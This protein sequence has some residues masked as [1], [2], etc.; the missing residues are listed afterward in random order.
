[1]ALNDFRSYPSAVLEFEPGVTVFVGENGQG[2]T[3]IVEAIAYLATFS[4]HR[5]AADAALV[6][7]GGP[8]AVIRAKAHDGERE[9]LLEIEIIAGRANRARLNRGTVKP[10]ELLG[11]LRAVVFAPEDLQLVSGDPG[12]RRRFLDDAAIQQRPRMAG[13]RAEYDKVLR[14]RTALLKSSAAARRRGHEIDKI[15]FA[16]WDER[17]AELGAQIIAHRAELVRDLRPHVRAMYEKIAPGRGVPHLAY[18]AN[19]DEASKALLAPHDVDRGE[20]DLEREE[21]LRDIA[22]VRDRLQVSIA[23]LKDREIDRGVNLVGP[24]RDDLVLGLGTLPAKGFASH[25]ET[26]S[27]ALSLRLAEWALL[28]ESD[29]SDPILILDD[30]F[31]ELDVRRRSALAEFVVGTEQVFI[32][33]A[34]GDAIPPQLDGSRFRVHEGVVSRDR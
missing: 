24:H 21:S 23:A 14:Q 9:T 4:S 10:R 30:V 15:S 18:E 20:G 25:G 13:L 8:A 33:S 28:R 6:R 27:Y 7:Q 29:D 31:A 5:V 3:N 34:V 1:M 17:L 26:W 16:V 22:A 2:K 32:T 12:V 11:I 19:V